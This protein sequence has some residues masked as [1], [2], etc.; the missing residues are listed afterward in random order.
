M[1]VLEFL[2]FVFLL[3]FGF[4]CFVFCLLIEGNNLSGLLPLFFLIQLG[5][6]VNPCR[7]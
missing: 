1:N 2:S 6:I 4:D 7:S 5:E 3:L